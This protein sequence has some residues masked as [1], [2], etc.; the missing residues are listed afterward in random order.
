[1]ESKEKLAHEY[2]KDFPGWY[3]LTTQSFIAGFEKAEELLKPKWVNVEESLPE[4]W[5]KHSNIYESDEVLL[6]CGDVF[7]VRR[8]VRILDKNH[9]KVIFEGFNDL[10]DQSIV[11]R[12]M[13]IPH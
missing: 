11:D 1:M 13:K 4:P 5:S 7:L 2:E 12:W 9:E 3:D 8:Y 10:E 6:D